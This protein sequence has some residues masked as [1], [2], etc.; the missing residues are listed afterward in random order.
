[1]CENCFK[2]NYVCHITSE[3]RLLRE[4]LLKQTCTLNWKER[5]EPL[6]RVHQLTFGKITETSRCRSPRPNFSYA[7]N[8]VLRMGPKSN[9]PTQQSS[10]TLAVGLCRRLPIHQRA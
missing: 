1:M 4:K 8:A 9:L 3:L 10:G 5:R 7:R 6:F 2:L